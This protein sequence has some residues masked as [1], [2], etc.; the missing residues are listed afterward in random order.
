MIDIEK[1]I[2]LQVLDNLPL[3]AL[4][5]DARTAEWAVV[6]VNPVLS[7]LTGGLEP[8]DLVGRSWCSLLVDPEE[9][10][11]QRERLLGS[12]ALVVRQLRQRWQSRSGHPVDLELQV[13][14]LFDGPGQA[15]YWLVTA[16]AHAQNTDEV[17]GEAL[18]GALRDAHIRLRQ[19]DWNDPVT[20]LLSRRAFTQLVQRDWLIAR[21]E[22]D[23]M[24]VIVFRLD[25]FD[26]YRELYGKH[27]ADSCVR[28]VA[29]AITGAMRRAGDVAGR[30][31]DDRFGVLIGSAEEAQA[32][33]FA[34]QIAR[35]VREL[36][37]HHPRSPIGRF[38]TL[39]FGL[40]SEVPARKAPSCLLVKRAESELRL[41]EEPE[42]DLEVG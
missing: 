26:K 31:A 13:S 37:I 24:T 14:P 28:K 9:L 20:G 32:A 34:S 40:G 29:H 42:D 4:I 7:Q 41:P 30:I 10:E 27:A 16:E 18:R 2:L 15:A 17:E 36:A 35:K 19:M 25:A 3:G 22:Q 39:S 11:S 5:V 12:P 23:R 21:R 33:Q 8:T 6:Y 38:V 1:Q